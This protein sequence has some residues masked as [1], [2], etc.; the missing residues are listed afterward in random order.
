M[1]SEEFV[2]TA[3]AQVLLHIMTSR[4]GRFGSRLNEEFYFPLYKN[5]KTWRLVRNERFLNSNVLV[6]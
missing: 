2:Y 4:T 1:V 5:V 6:S 3:N